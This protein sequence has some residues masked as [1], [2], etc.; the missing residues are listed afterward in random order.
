MERLY[1]PARAV[2]HLG[3]HASRGELLALGCDPTFIKLSLWYR[4][5]VPTRRGWYASRDTPLAV[6]H[7]LRAGGR[8]ACVSALAWH[9]GREVL[10]LVHVLVPYGVSRPRREGA[11]LHW[12]RREQPG[13][14]LVVDEEV[15]RRQAATCRASR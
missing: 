7:A 4:T 11:T 5:I 1:L 14:R 10:G 8:L 3:G 2:A 15:A 6:L 13:T 12:S 9:E